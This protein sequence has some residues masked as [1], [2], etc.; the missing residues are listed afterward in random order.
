MMMMNKNMVATAPLFLFITTKRIVLISLFRRFQTKGLSR[1]EAEVCAR[2]VRP[3]AR[4]QAES[5]VLSSSSTLVQL[6][7]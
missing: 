1:C 6:Y 3:A 4:H 7:T 5:V 2:Q